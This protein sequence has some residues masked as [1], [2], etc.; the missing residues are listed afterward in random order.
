MSREAKQT[1][2]GAAAIIWAFAQINNS[3]P[4]SLEY[5]K[6]KAKKESERGNKLKYKERYEY[7]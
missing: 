7:V 4:S 2:L 6:A 1:Y 3:E 5:L